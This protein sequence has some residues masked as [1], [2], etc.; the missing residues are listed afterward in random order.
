MRA[1]SARYLDGSFQGAYFAASPGFTRPIA[2]KLHPFECNH[3]SPPPR[4]LETVAG[5]LSSSDAAVDASDVLLLLQT[6]LC[7]MCAACSLAGSAGAWGARSV[8]YVR[9]F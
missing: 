4:P 5:V 3:N 2:A 1:A 8:Q 7:V 6:I 9:T